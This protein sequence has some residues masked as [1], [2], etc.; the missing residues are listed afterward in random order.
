VHPAEYGSKLM[1]AILHCRLVV[2]PTGQEEQ[3]QGRRR[4]AWQQHQADVSAVPS[5]KRAC[6]RLY[7]AAAA[8][9]HV[10]P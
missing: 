4:P 2:Q 3:Q 6:V 5:D 1:K 7:I 8:T 9:R 10:K